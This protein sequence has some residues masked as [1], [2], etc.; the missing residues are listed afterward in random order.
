MLDPALAPQEGDSV[1]RELLRS[2][3]DA[4]AYAQIATRGTWEGVFARQGRGKGK[5][6]E[7]V[8]GHSS[9][10]SVNEDDAVM[11]I[12]K[13]VESVQSVQDAA[14]EAEK[15]RLKSGTRGEGAAVSKGKGREDGLGDPLMEEQLEESGPDKKRT[16]WM[17]GGKS[18]LGPSPGQR[19]C[20]LSALSSRL[21]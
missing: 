11:E 16:K 13:A 6:E 7:L 12:L 14:V 20:V 3:V 18:V 4:M 15:S 2:W 17:R 5:K 1:T 9:L 8:G 10:R 19:A 21:S